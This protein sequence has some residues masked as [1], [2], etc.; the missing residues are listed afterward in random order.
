[1]AEPIT[2]ISIVLKAAGFIKDNWRVL[3]L[4]FLVALIFP[5]FIYV[6]VTSILLARIDQNIFDSYTESS[7]ENEINLSVLISYDTIRYFNDMEKALPNES[8]F[9]FLVIDYL[10]YEVEE[11]TKKREEVIIEENIVRQFTEVVDEVEIEMAVE[12]E[13]ILIESG[14]SKGYDQIMQMLENKLFSYGRN[15]NDVTI[16]EV[17]EYLSDLDKTDAFGIDCYILS[18]EEIVSSFTRGEKL[19]FNGLSKMLAKMY[20]QFYESGSAP[21]AVIIEEGEQGD[22]VP[23]IWS[24]NG[25]VTGYFGELRS[26]GH[27]HKGIDIA[28]ISG[29]NIYAPGSG[30]VILTGW[31]DEYGNTIMIHHG[32]GITT[33]YGHLKKILVRRGQIISRGEVIGLVGSTGVSTGPHLHYEIRI[34]GKRV[35]PMNYLQ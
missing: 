33:L 22:Y 31:Q 13:F 9:D 11:V 23:S 10:V 24:V 5:Y 7:L 19:W 18:A 28:A 17:V 14:S 34:N 4:S 2:I 30:T 29:S 1:M 3:L 20:P 25:Y 21:Y 32:S 35:D 8:V 16:P 12:K 26:G 15:M 6:I 27:I